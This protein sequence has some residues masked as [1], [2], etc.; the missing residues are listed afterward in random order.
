MKG[1]GIASGAFQR[2]SPVL[3]SYES[4][5][6]TVVLGRIWAGERVGEAT[7]Q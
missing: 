2:A 1:L 6:S 5:R 4:V 3:A 7:E